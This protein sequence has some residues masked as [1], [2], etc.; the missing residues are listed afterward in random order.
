M[1]VT[2][3]N[4]LDNLLPAPA[5]ETAPVAPPAPS[6]RPPAAGATESDH[7]D[8]SNVA[9]KLTE[10][11]Q[12]DSARAERIRQLREAVANDTYQPD[13]EAVS[14]ALIDEAIGG[15]STNQK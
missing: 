12:P 3:P 15:R 2:D 5:A 7:A 8:L 6:H 11:L 4:N 1:R 14:R 10:M 9:G 13:A